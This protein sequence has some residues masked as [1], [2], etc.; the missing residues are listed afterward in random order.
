MTTLS[1]DNAGEDGLL[2]LLVRGVI[3]SLCVGSWPL[4]G[5]FILALLVA[6]RDRVLMR[7]KLL[8][9]F[10]FSSSS[11]APDMVFPPVARFSSAIGINLMRPRSDGTPKPSSIAF[12]RRI[13]FLLLVTGCNREGIALIVS[14]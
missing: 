7:L 4:G 3:F 9:A 13:A 11:V 2:P 14:V 8:D 10:S 1:L 6:A 12:E 5:D